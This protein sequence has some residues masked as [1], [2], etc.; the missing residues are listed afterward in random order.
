LSSDSDFTGTA[1][2]IDSVFRMSKVHN[3]NKSLAKK[4]LARISDELMGKLE[5]KLFLPLAY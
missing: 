3:L 5:K 4:R 2:K 1:L